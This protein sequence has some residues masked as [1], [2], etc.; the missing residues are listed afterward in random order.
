M[1]PPTSALATPPRTPS[2]PSGGNAARI[3]QSRAQA[4][5]SGSFGSSASVMRNR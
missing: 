1:S 5:Q 4:L 3:A 2:Q